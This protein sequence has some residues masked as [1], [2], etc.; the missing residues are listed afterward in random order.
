MRV[1][2]RQKL[3]LAYP[4]Y[5]IYRRIV[6]GALS[7]LAMVEVYHRWQYLSIV[8]RMIFKFFSFDFFARCRR[9]FPADGSAPMQA[10]RPLAG[11]IAKKKDSR[12]LA[13]PAV[14][15]HEGLEVWEYHSRQKLG[16]AY[17]LYNIHRRRRSPVSAF[18]VSLR[19]L[20]YSTGF[21]SCQ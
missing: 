20:Y 2:S 21:R 4:P 14:L 1:F 8:L 12:A 9:H 15:T 16:L 17:P 5:N 13:F 3:G 7:F 6:S 18:L 10:R 19:W 11:R